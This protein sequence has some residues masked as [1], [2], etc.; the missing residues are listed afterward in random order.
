MADHTSNHGRGPAPVEAPRPVRAYERIVE[1]VEER[2]LRG[3]LA[4]GDRLPSEREMMTHF[5]VSR[6]TVREALRMLESQ[7]MVRSRPGDPRGPEIRP[8]DASFLRKAVARM[9]GL[10]EVGLGELV[11]FRMLLEGSAYVL[12]AQLATEAQL[13]DLDAALVDMAAAL[14]GGH[15]EFGRADVAFHDA[16]VAA[17]GSTL[18]QVCSDVVRGVVTGIITHKLA[19][20]PVEE[21]RALMVE[22]VRHH[23]E[24]LAAVRAGDGELASRLARAALHQY[25]AGYLAE[26]D[27]RKIGAMAP[28]PAPQPEL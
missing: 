13:D 15:E 6:S 7:G 19:S 27:Q 24:V 10:D 21:R 14:D 20:S 22:S 8:F 2:V 26:A 4:P 12:A 3:E 28:Q 1:H 18:I 17:T 5:G 25:Y 9:A 11:Q 16:V 23:A